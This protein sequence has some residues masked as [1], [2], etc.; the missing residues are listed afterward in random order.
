MP[1][2][3]LL[4]CLLLVS[5]CG[6][7]AIAQVEQDCPVEDCPGQCGRFIDQNGDGFCDHRQLS[8]K[9]AALAARR[10][11]Y[12]QAAEQESSSDTLSTP[13]AEPGSNPRET[14]HNADKKAETPT[15]TPPLES[16]NTNASERETTDTVVTTNA[17]SPAD[18]ETP[19]P[20]KYK[21]P[22]SLILISTLTLG[23]YLISS[24]LVKTNTLKKS[25][26]RKIWNV[27]LLITGLVS[28]LLGFFLVIQINY[29]LKM[30]WFRIVKL[31]HVQFGIAM[32]IVMIIH[33][34]WHLNYW[35]TLFRTKDKKSA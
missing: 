24:I 21:S 16:T 25:T 4:L 23:L 13:A 6:L 2:L 31:Y 22:Y 10:I 3:K 34:L 19:Q 5:L 27:L 20:Q 8:A 29:N 11:A 30:E 7:R 14:S 12:Q 9:V 32:T 33:I 18:E 35:K 1:K 28:C 17:I 15:S 26:H